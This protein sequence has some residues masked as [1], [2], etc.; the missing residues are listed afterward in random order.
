[1]NI[2]APTFVPISD[3][4]SPSSEHT[5]DIKHPGK[6]SVERQQP[7]KHQNKPRPNHGK[8]NNRPQ[9]HHH[10]SSQKTNKAQKGGLLHE[11]DAKQDGQ[12]LSNVSLH[13]SLEVYVSV[14]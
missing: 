6:S 7:R 2:N 8:G 14:L 1:M 10:N 9:H 4:K 13:W 11:V 3:A 5:Q 12:T